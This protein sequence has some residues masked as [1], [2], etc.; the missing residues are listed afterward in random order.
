MGLVFPDHALWPGMSV[1]ENVAYPLK[2]RGVSGPER[3]R[4]VA[5]T[6]ST[7]RIDSLAGKR[8]EHLLMPRACGLPWRERSSPS[9]SF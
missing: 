9:P 4:R 8:P 3:R 5:E 1:S 6:L 7:L 2:V